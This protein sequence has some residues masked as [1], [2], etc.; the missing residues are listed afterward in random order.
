MNSN[1]Q[2]LF[3]NDAQLGNLITENAKIAKAEIDEIKNKY[4]TTEKV[5]TDYMNVKFWTSAGKIRADRIDAETIVGKL[6]EFNSQVKIGHDIIVGDG[7]HCNRITF[8]NLSISVSD[9]W[10]DII[11]GDKL[12]KVLCKGG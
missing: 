11:V 7:V 1:I 12:Y 5:E 2:N 8:G 10:Q 4:I 3:A 6:G 9:Y